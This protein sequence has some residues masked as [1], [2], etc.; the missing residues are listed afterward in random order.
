MRRSSFPEYTIQNCLSWPAG[1][2]TVEHTYSFQPSSSPCTA[3]TAKFNDAFKFRCLFRLAFFLFR[4]CSRR[5]HSLCHLEAHLHKL[6]ALRQGPKTR[7]ATWPIASRRQSEEL[8]LFKIT[9]QRAA[10]RRR[11]LRAGTGSAQALSPHSGYGSR[12]QCFCNCHSQPA[13]A[14]GGTRLPIAPWAPQGPQLQ[15]AARSSL[16]SG[17]E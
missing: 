7:P 11:S 15:L 2:I 12:Q 9:T 17:H 4:C 8:Q 5:R 3:I 1:Y 13:A 14:G 10:R 6:L 16:P